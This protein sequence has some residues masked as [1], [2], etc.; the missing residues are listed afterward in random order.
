[1][2]RICHGY[3]R[4]YDVVLGKGTEATEGSRAVVHYEARWKGVTFMTSR[5]A[6][7]HVCRTAQKGASSC[8]EYGLCTV[9]MRSSCDILVQRHSLRRTQ[10][11]LLTLTAS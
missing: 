10:A 5:L 6:V 8:Q 9:L 2:L 3:V 4:Y 7:Q 11:V 1:M